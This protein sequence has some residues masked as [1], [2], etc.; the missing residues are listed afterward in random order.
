M[1][2]A[3]YLSCNI[4]RINSS[5]HF[6]Q[7]TINCNETIHI[8][9]REIVQDICKLGSSKVFKDYFGTHNKLNF[10]N[11][12]V[13]LEPTFL[14]I[15]HNVTTLE[16][17]KN[18][19]FISHTMYSTNVVGHTVNGQVKLRPFPCDTTH[20]W[21]CCVICKHLWLYYWCCICMILVHYKSIAS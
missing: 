5:P 6:F 18:K 8:L 1:L 10:D 16:R 2:T 7:A 9:N 21:A 11:K 13:V 17:M 3:H 14:W 19:Y 15:Y 4:Q 12:S 20:I